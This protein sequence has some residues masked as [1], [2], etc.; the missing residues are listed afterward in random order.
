MDIEKLNGAP[1]RNK[2]VFLERY[3]IED[4]LVAISLL[5]KRSNRLRSLVSLIKRNGIDNLYCPVC[6]IK[7]DNISLSVD[8]GGGKH[9]DLFSGDHLL[10]IDHI[11]PKSKDGKNNLTNYQLMC[12]ICNHKKGGK[13]SV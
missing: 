2:T 1:I 10:T 3:T 7:A 12:R 11:V 6:N 4:G 8:K 5:E 13:L 9:W